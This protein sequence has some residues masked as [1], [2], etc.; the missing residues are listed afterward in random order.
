MKKF[1]FS[2]FAIIALSAICHAGKITLIQGKD[3]YSGCY[4]DTYYNYDHW[5]KRHYFQQ[6]LNSPSF[7][8]NKSFARNKGTTIADIADYCC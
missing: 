6:W 5:D 4:T 1:G 2:L 3:G 8:T 7:A